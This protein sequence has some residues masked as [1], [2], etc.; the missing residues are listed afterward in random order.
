MKW[1][2][3]LLVVF[4]VFLQIRTTNGEEK[5]ETRSFERGVELYS[6]GDFRKAL[7]IFEELYNNT[8]DPL[9]LY[10]IGLCLFR[11]KRYIEAKERFEQFLKKGDKNLPKNLIEAT[12]LRLEDLR[13]YLGKFTLK[14]K[15]KEGIAE[16]YIDGRKIGKISDGKEI[17][18]EKGT[19]LIFIKRGEDE[20]WTKEIDVKGGEEETLVVEF[21]TEGRSNKVE[22]IKSN[23]EKTSSLKRFSPWSWISLG[24][25]IALSITGIILIAI[26][27]YCPEDYR[28]AE[29]CHPDHPEVVYNT[30]TPGIVVTSIG[31][32]I[33]ITGIILIIS[34]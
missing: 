33:S 27:G 32:A 4:L 5:E 17:I 23:R 22:K 26:D 31:G 10:H 7:D 29:G 11:L 21:K 3:N 15:D 6:E 12:K 13:Q 30:L 1:I 28:T 2:C 18:L 24:V 9:Y 25:G 8:A 20:I 16:Y 34:F 14:L 19:H